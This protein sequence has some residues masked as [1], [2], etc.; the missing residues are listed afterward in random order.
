MRTPSTRQ[1]MCSGRVSICWRER[2]GGTDGGWK[3]MKESCEQMEV[4]QAGLCE[5]AR[6]EVKQLKGDLS[7]VALQRR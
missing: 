7:I 2:L 5:M 1:S 4:E 3:E 6:G